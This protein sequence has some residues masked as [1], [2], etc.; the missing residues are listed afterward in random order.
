MNITN[1]D[2]IIF[3]YSSDDEEEN[4]PSTKSQDFVEKWQRK[5]NGSTGRYF[6]MIQV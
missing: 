6:K 2:C 4:N 1:W 3:A 5:K